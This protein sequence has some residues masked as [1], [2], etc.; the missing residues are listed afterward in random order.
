VILEEAFGFANPRHKRPCLT[1]N[2]HRICSVSKTFTKAAIHLLISQGKLEMD[3]PVFPEVFGKL[4]N[5]SICEH[6]E[7]ITI[8]HLLE[9]KVGAWPTTQRQCDP[10]FSRQHCSHKILI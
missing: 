4:F 9:H 3:T 2:F 10:M 6:S 7:K 5:Y 8:R 1:S